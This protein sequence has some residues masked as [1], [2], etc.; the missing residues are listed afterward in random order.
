MQKH[1]KA[2]RQKTQNGQNARVSGEQGKRIFAGVFLAAAIFLLVH[3]CSVCI[4]QVG[5]LTRC[6]LQYGR[7]SR[8]WSAFLT[9]KD[10]LG[11]G[12]NAVEAFSQSYQVLTGG[13]D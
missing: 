7:E 12:Q 6:V 1:E 8:A 10:G 5:Q 11:A 3:T 9:L 13:A 4:P 2:T